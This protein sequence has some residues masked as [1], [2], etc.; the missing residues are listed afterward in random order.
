MSKCKTFYKNN[1]L[2][3]TTTPHVYQNMNIVLWRNLRASWHLLGKKKK[4][5]PCIKVGCLRPAVTF[6]LRSIRPHENRPVFD[7]TVLLGV[8]FI[9]DEEMETWGEDPLTSALLR[10]PQQWTLCQTEGWAELQ[11]GATTAAPGS[12]GFDDTETTKMKHTLVS[13]W[14]SFTECSARNSHWF[15]FQR[16]V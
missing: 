7:L 14:N 6:C 11:P 15:G 9:R 12:F 3:K 8:Q 2:Y 5:T 10:L 16:D 13:S 1:V 4:K